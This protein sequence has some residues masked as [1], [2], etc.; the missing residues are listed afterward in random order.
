MPHTRRSTACRRPS[1]R[2]TASFTSTVMFRPSPGTIPSTPSSSPSSPE[3]SESKSGR[4][5]T[6]IRTSEHIE[7]R[8]SPPTEPRVT[9]VRTTERPSSAIEHVRAGAPP[10]PPT[11]D[12]RNEWR[13][14]DDGRAESR[15][16]VP[17]EVARSSSRIEGSTPVR[18]ASSSPSQSAC[19]SSVSSGRLSD[20]N[21]LANFDDRPVALKEASDIAPRLLEPSPATE[22]RCPR[23]DARHDERSSPPMR[24]ER[25]SSRRPSSPPRLST[26]TVAHAENSVRR[27]VR[28]PEAPDGA[29][30]PASSRSSLGSRKP[31]AVA[32]SC[33]RISMS[34]AFCRRSRR[35]AVDDRR[36]IAGLPRSEPKSRSEPSRDGCWLAESEGGSESES[37]PGW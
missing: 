6:D 19:S 13:A 37:R 1:E 8:T 27:E 21:F 28:S 15:H 4:D 35:R 31:S 18:R 2:P 36:T 9:E 32:S 33:S 26:V 22:D 23:H 29:T 5:A 16:E 11:N 14:T 17:N 3:C 7:P 20:D 34:T 25:S 24:E 30:R 10:A 12:T